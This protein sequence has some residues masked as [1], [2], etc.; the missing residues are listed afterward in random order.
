MTRS[1]N[2][3]TGWLRPARRAT[4]RLL[5]LCLL[6]LLGLP[7]S[8]AGR[9]P[10]AASAAAKGPALPPYVYVVV[11]GLATYDVLR[12]ADGKESRLARI[13]TAG[14]GFGEVVAA[15]APGGAYVAVRATGTTSSGG[16]SLRLIEIKSSRAMTI[17]LSRTAEMGIGPFAWAPDGK[18]LAYTAATPQPDDAESG[19]GAI[20]V[21][22]A[23]GRGARKLAGTGKGRLVGWSPDGSGVYFAR[24]VSDDKT[25]PAEDL[26]F[27]PLAGQATAVLRSSPGG[28]V[29]HRFVVSAAQ[30]PGGAPGA[31]YIAALASDN[32][33]TLGITGRAATLAPAPVGAASEAVRSRPP[34]RVLPAASPAVLV[35]DGK[36]TYTLLPDKGEDYTM[37]AWNPVDGHVLFSGGKSHAAW[38]ADAHTGQRW[39]LPRALNNLAP[40]AWSVDGRYVLLGGARS[41]SIR[42]IT[43]DTTNGKLVRSR[44]VG[45]SGKAGEAVKNLS[46]PYVNQL[47]DTDT[48]FNGNW[49][50]GPA[51][52][53]MV[54]AYYGRLAP[55]P[56]PPDKARASA[57]DHI[58]AHSVGS[59]AAPSDLLDGHLYGQYITTAFSYKTHI[60]QATSLDPTGRRAA[61]LYG[62]IVGSDALAHWERMIDVLGLYGLNTSYLPL[63]WSVIT[64]MLDKGYPVVLGTTLTDSGHILV[65]RGYTANG[66]LLV[67]DPYGNRFGPSGY[68]ADDGGNAAYAWKKLPLKL[69]MV[70]RGTI[71]PPATPT[72]TITP[73]LTLTATATPTAVRASHG[74]GGP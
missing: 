27:L 18:S 16:S 56:L 59:E 31:A 50:C 74:A 63:S 20:W 68:G 23:D 52:V 49:A 33:T 28:P 10:D 43:L 9:P 67:N 13:G 5:H 35:G 26:W 12:V 65:A 11:N 17:T 51:S 21:V 61:G 46:L 8:L 3:G 24:T 72:P 53:T 40:I 1:Y 4:Q 73:T 41:P 62:A 47:W 25:N 14:V 54:L 6:A 37:L 58:H 34:A 44:D 48:S 64:G 39:P 45:D 57:Q 32:V 22:G 15:L 36:G 29:Y 30:V 71:T 2:K 7:G 70:V 60:F 69:A 55:W 66:Y 38:Y 42:L 19:V